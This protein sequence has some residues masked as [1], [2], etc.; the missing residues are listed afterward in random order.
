VLRLDRAVTRHLEAG[1]LYTD[2]T[3][4]QLAT[5][6]GVTRSVFY[7]HFEDKGALLVSLAAGAMDDMLDAAEVWWALPGR[8]TPDDV[9]DVL[10][11]IF[12]AYD[13]HAV[14]LR[15]VSERAA[16]DSAV[17]APFLDLVARTSGA[18]AD[19]VRQGQSDGRIDRELDPDRTS[20]WL[21]WMTQGGLAD[22]LGSDRPAGRKRRLDALARIVW[23]TLYVTD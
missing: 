2:I 4:A 13:R 5:E 8:P 22:P 14:L 1:E 9:R 3:V 19:Y 11:L 21:T 12:A 15:A 18:L 17:D 10:A 7:A 6:A 16:H 23:S 20:A